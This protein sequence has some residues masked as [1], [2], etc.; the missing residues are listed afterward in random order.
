MASDA[1]LETVAIYRDL[2]V[3]A[4]ATAQAL[5]WGRVRRAEAMLSPPVRWWRRLRR[6][7]QRLPDSPGWPR[8]RR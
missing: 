4:E 6:A 5:A 8:R 1:F 2:G 7:A 3:L